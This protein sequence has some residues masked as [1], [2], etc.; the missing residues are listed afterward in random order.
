MPSSVPS[1]TLAE[2]HASESAQV[3][4]T[5]EATGDGLAAARERSRLVDKI[6]T[7]LYC[8]LLSPDANGPPGF[9]LAGVGGYGRQE[10]FPH[11]DV[12]LLFLSES[13][14]V[15]ESFRQPVAAIARSLWDLRLRV[16]HSART[17]PEC[18]RL[19]RDNM[20][21]SVS[22]LDCR[23]LAGDRELFARLRDEVTPELMA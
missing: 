23:F 20:E 11:S 9:C 13:G 7:Q 17:L 22:L 21:F 10:L 6:V 1:S 16:G 14:Q 15:S 2:L 12:D 8:D 18:G 4:Q 19:E 5:F 3:R